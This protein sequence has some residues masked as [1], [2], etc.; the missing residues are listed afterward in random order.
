MALAGVHAK[1]LAGAGN[2]KTL[3]G[4]AMSLQFQFRF[5]SIAWHSV[6]PRFFRLQ[7]ASK[8]ASFCFSVSAGTV[9]PVS[10]RRNRSVR[11]DLTDL[12]VPLNW[13]DLVLLLRRRLFSEPATPPGHYL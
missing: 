6:N 5:R 11:L 1:Q 2:L 10:W 3:G 12:S 8:P 9:V 4:A 13:A 7:R